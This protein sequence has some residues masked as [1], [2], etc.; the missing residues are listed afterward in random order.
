MSSQETQAVLEEMQLNQDD[1]VPEIS[2]PSIQGT[3]FIAVRDAS[4][5]RH[6][7]V[8]D[9]SDRCMDVSF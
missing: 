9:V 6:L 7:Y 4:A 8:E 2:M 3:Q 1:L 5:V